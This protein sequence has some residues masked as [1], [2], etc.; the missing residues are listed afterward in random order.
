M[1]VLIG[2]RSEEAPNVSG[3]DRVSTDSLHGLHIVRR[4]EH[5]HVQRRLKNDVSDVDQSQAKDGLVEIVNRYASRIKRRLN[6]AHHLARKDRI[7]RDEPRDSLEVDIG[8]AGDVQEL[9]RNRGQYRR[10][11]AG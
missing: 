8:I 10:L 11:V 9:D 1:G 6:S 3:R 4:G 5:T 2:H 7:S